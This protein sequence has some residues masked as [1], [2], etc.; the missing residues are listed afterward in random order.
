M[1]NANP[2]VFFYYTRLIAPS[3][4]FRVTVKQSNDNPGFKLFATHQGQIRLW[5]VGCASFVQGVGGT[6]PFI[7]ITGATAG[8]TYVLSVKYDTKSISGSTFTGAFGPDV[9]YSFN[10]YFGP[11]ASV[12]IPG[13][14]GTIVAKDKALGCSSVYVNPGSCPGPAAPAVNTS[15]NTRVSNINAEKANEL[16]ATAYPNPYT[17]QIRLNIKSPVSGMAIIQFYTV[18]GAM[19]SEMRQYVQAGIDNVVKVKA[20][21][22]IK[23]NIIYRINV[24]NFN[25]NGTVIKPE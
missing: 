19:V 13:S 6:A 7:N 11:T 23:S 21:D 9:T 22:Q 16:K 14:D 10:A 20:M 3:S 5:T 24:G 8:T 15:V 4:S 18:N 25:T 1:N 12:F 17:S 2:G